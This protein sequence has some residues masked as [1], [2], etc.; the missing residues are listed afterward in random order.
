MT[1]I[2]ERHYKDHKHM[3][4]WDDEQLEAHAQKSHKKLIEMEPSAEESSKYWVYGRIPS[5]DW[6][7]FVKKYG[8]SAIIPDE[9]SANVPKKKT[10]KPQSG[11][12]KAD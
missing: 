9:F 5:P 10:R 12:K 6:G 2:A 3:R 1:A 11:N 4:K 8:E 7:L